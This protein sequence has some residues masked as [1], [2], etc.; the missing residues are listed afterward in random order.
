MPEGVKV[1]RNVHLVRV[2]VVSKE[3]EVMWHYM[4]TQYSIVL[5]YAKLY[6][7]VYAKLYCI[8]HAKLPCTTHAKLYCTAYAK[9]YCTAHAKKIFSGCHEFGQFRVKNVF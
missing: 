1:S 6:C 3:S 4:V 5:H 8:A 9:L 2:A 7:T